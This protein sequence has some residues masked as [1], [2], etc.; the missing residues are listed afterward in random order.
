MGKIMRAKVA[1]AAVAFSIAGTASAETL[2]LNCRSTGASNAN[3]F[4]WFAKPPKDV[5]AM[6]KVLWDQGVVGFAV[7]PPTTWE[8]T[9]PSGAIRDPESD[10]PRWPTAIVKPA[11]I[12]AI[13]YSQSGSHFT[14][15]FNR[16][17]NTVTLS[18]VLDEKNRKDWQAKFGKPFPL[19]IRH[20][21]QCM[22]RTV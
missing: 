4:E 16:I 7:A 5:E 21:Q 13:A 14:F 22:V 2:L 6:T 8:I 1:L 19:I 18:D 17:D 12:V 10:Q 20:K 3:A 11:S 15:T 9:L